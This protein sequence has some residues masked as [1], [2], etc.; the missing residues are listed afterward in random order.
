MIRHTSSPRR[1]HCVG[2][3]STG[4]ASATPS[5][6]RNF[7]DASTTPG[8]QL[9]G[10]GALWP[11]PCAA[12]LGGAKQGSAHGPWRQ[13]A[14]GYSPAARPAAGQGET[15]RH[16]PLLSHLGRS[17]GVGGRR[18][19]GNRYRP[20]HH[21]HAITNLSLP[22]FPLTLRRWSEGGR[23]RGREGDVMVDGGKAK[24]KSSSIH[25]SLPPRPPS[26]PPPSLPKGLP[27]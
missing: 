16:R 15:A 19:E 22:S 14:G 27:L 13:G 25:P 10:V 24:L 5:G 26:L 12:A 8:Y 9:H 7:R 3:A 4:H 6:G 1:Q 11:R 20:S 18:E 21:Q 23:K 2:R 17:G